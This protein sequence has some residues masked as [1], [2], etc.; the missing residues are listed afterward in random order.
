MK[1]CPKCN[2]EKPFEEF[3]NDSGNADGFYHYCKE[4]EKIR[5]RQYYL[6]NQEEIKKEVREYTILNKKKISINK[7]RYY[8]ENKERINIYKKDNRE[9]RNTTQREYQRNRYKNDPMFRLRASVSTL[10]RRSLRNNKNG[11]HWETL[12]DYKQED[13]R[14]HLEAQFK[15][16]MTWENYGKWQIDHKIPISLFNIKNAKSKG[17]KKCW[18]LENIQPLW[19][20]ENLE[21]RD[22]LFYIP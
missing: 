22:N 21:K 10:I 12:V 16:G 20:K 2:I 13:L 3:Q 1:R 5:K 11:Y 18:A 19:A 14:N 17:F 4:C 15:D 7:K 6:D 8:L 9:R